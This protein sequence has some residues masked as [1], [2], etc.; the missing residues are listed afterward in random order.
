MS[1]Q[2]PPLTAL[3]AFDAAARH[4]SFRQ[5]AEELHVTPAAISQQIKLL[6]DYLGVK[7]FNRQGRSLTLSDQGHAGLA[8]LREGFTLLSEAV[9]Q[10]RDYDRQRTLTIYVPPSLASKW[11]IPKLHRFALQYPDI[12]YRIIA[13]DDLIDESSD[14]ETIAD[15]LRHHGVDIAIRFGRGDYEGC[16]V[17]QLLTVTAVPLCS[18][19]LLEGEHPL[20]NPEDLRYHTLLHDDTSYP[21]H[22]QWR[23]WLKE[24]GVKSVDADR[25][26]H[27]NHVA[28]AMAAA[29]E[30][31]GV[32][33]S[34]KPLAANDIKAGRLMVPFDLSL[35][36]RHAYYLISPEPSAN[37]PNV[38]AFR[39]WLLDEVAPPEL[40]AEV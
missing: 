11:L 7:L 37:Q 20:R 24:A 12:D 5:A 23:A 14:P 32:V 25:G 10:I 31:Q 35:P 13:D 40:A 8:K 18:P 2:L 27:F 16:R 19:K 3:R 34:L 38:A 17:D 28:L 9:R 39:N 4:S 1:E 33:L 26:L 36:L 29:I 22:P 30:G 15:D 6:E 21:G